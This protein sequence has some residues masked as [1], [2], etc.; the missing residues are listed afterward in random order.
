[1]IMAG[2][3]WAAWHNIVWFAAFFIATML[4]V[5]SYYRTSQRITQLVIPVRRSLLLSG[6]QPW[7]RL[8]KLAL[9]VLALLFLFIA[10]LGPQWNEK[11][12]LIDQQGRDVL[13]ALDVSRSM[14][15]EDIKPN[16][17]SFAKE[18]IK[19]LITQL[20]T[21][22]VGLI[23]FAGDAFVHCPLTHDIHAFGQFLDQVDA[24][25]ISSGTTAIDK[26]L[27]KAIQVYESMP[28]RKHGLVVAFTDGEDYSSNLSAIKARASNLGM[29]V[30]TVG[31]GSLEGAPVPI[32]DK[33][34][35]KNGYEKE[36]SGQ[37]VMSRLNE[38]ILE[39]LARDVGGVYVHATPG[40]D[41]DIQ[42]IVHHVVQF[43]KEAFDQTRVASLEEKYY[44]F[45][46]MSFMCFLLEWLL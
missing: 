13:I 30:F 17:L 27:S 42:K 3:T 18:K 23:L 45:V 19:Q 15:A 25:T 35:K 29:H 10:L 6:A 1:M 11:E 12:E 20:K 43:E 14:L 22:R 32:V 9:W 41:A 5:Y 2:I 21:E 39:T 34:G 31:V 28:N 7:L 36:T 16:R 37:V 38:G 44:Y 24:N 46:A 26:A 4:L 33:E 40:S 8:V